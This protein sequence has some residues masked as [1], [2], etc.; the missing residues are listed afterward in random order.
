[1]NKENLN[2]KYILDDY[3]P[4]EREML[5]EELSIFKS[6]NDAIPYMDCPYALRYDYKTSSGSYITKCD[7]PGGC[8]YKKET[9]RTG[10]GIVGEC[11]KILN[12]KG[13]ER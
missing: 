9:T 8:K 10:R 12:Y 13:E 5:E 11:T 7:C 3:D 6:P 4:D 2:E 1:M